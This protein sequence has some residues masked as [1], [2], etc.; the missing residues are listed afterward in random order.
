MRLLVW[1]VM[2]VSAVWVSAICLIVLFSK[3]G[4]NWLPAMFEPGVESLSEPTL[5]ATWIGLPTLL[6]LG[7]Q[8]WQVQRVDIER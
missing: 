6:C 4:V 7:M 3:L 8:I 5:F 2:L 1:S